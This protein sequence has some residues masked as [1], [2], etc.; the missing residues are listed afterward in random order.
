MKPLYTI[1]LIFALTAS[2][3]SDKTK[4]QTEVEKELSIVEKIAN[5]HGFENW[6]NVTEVQFTF[7]VDR[8]TIKGNGRSWTWLPK[9]DSVYMRAGVQNVRYS[10][11]NLDSVPKN[12]D[13]AF[14]NDKYWAFVPF[15]LVWDKTATIS[16]AKKVEAPISKTQMDMITILYPSEGG[17][18]PGDAYDI[19]YDQ[20]YMIKEW[21]YRKGNSAEAS[22]SNTFE[23]YKDY[24]GI[25]IATDH[26]KDEG[27][28][29][30]NLTNI[31]IKTE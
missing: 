31:K 14:I 28:W 22:L 10:R 6:K 12:V 21:S 25:K 15:Q 26:K 30:L 19:Y 29:N 23:N 16:E 27:K 2:C 5:A 11:K 9:Q 13:R 7:A 24:N 1:L 3:K 8:D 18:T 20:N 17:Y 4:T